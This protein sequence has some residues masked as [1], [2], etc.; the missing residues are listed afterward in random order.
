MGSKHTSLLLLICPHC[1]ICMWGTNSKAIIAYSSH[2]HWKD[3][4]VY[5][6]DCVLLWMASVTVHNLHIVQNCDM[7][8]VLWL[9]G[10][11]VV[12]WVSSLP[13]H[14]PSVLMLK[15]STSLFGEKAGINGACC[16][17]N[18]TMLMVIQGI[19]QASTVWQQC[20]RLKNVAK[21]SI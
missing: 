6:C 11:G 5:Y 9:V 12:S 7:Q 15:T 21:N 13:A 17:G 3:E 10:G 1:V 14:F 18:S 2:S 19:V 8:G 4:R 16:Y 20:Y